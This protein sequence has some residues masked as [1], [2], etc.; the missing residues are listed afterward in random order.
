VG[1]QRAE[2]GK[3]GVTDRIYVVDKMP[4]PFE[5][6]LRELYYKWGSLGYWANRFFQTFSP[7]CKLYIG[8]VQAVRSV[9]PYETDGFR[10]LREKNRLDLSVESLMLKPEWRELFSDDEL[11]MATQKLV[12]NSK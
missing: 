2:G 10:F 8:G 1:S 6:A 7:H 4:T 3:S 5:A 9:L 11:A 12:K